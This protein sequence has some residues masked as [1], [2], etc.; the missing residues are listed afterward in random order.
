MIHSQL[1]GTGEFVVLISNLYLTS[2]FEKNVVTHDLFI[3]MLN[4]AYHPLYI[5]YIF[6]SHWELAIQLSIS[7]V[8]NLEMSVKWCD[9][10]LEE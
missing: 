1:I 7:A 9:V 8:F 4:Y 2:L 10:L 5:M 3:I 6:F